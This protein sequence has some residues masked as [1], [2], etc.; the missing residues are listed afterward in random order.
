MKMEVLV[1]EKFFVSLKTC[2]TYPPVLKMTTVTTELFQHA[3]CQYAKQI[4]P[5]N[6]SLP[7][8]LAR[9]LSLEE[10]K[11]FMSCLVPVLWGFELK[12]KNA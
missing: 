12:I 7:S 11:E 2:D 9:G 6:E 8:A 4:S 3:Y 5:K 10:E 1:F